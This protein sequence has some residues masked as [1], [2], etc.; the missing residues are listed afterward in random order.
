M[1]KLTW[2]DWLVRLGI[3]LF[4]FLSVGILLRM[5]LEGVMVLFIPIAILVALAK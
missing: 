4:M 3:A 1:R 2:L 5:E